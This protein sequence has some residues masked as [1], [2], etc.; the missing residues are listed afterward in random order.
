MMAGVW[1][2][3]ALAAAGCSSGSKPEKPAEEAKP[4]EPVKVPETYRV[5]FETTKGDFVV[6]VNR[7][8]APRGADRFHELVRTGFYDGARFYR[9]RP[10]FIVQFGISPNPE[11]NELWR[12]LKMPDDPVKQGNRSGYISFAQHGPGSRTTQV[13][14]NLANNSSL[15]DG[16]NFAAF[17]RVTDGMDIVDKIYG[18]YGE[19]QNLGGAGPDPIKME[20]QGDEYVQRSYPRLDQIKKATI[21]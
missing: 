17:G 12:Q 5:K 2:V 15:L 20:T 11:M 13:F 7:E 4:R 1:I 16:K 14:I 18:G 6:E 9:V 10:K 3:M 8:W 21:L 19:V